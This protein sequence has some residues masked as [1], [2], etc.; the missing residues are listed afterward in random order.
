M[1]IAIDFG[2][3]AQEARR[4][5]ERAFGGS[6]GLHQA[7]KIAALVAETSGPEGVDYLVAQ[8]ACPRRPAASGGPAQHHFG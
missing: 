1:S 8:G 5:L 2:R 6:A 4:T 7:G 3:T